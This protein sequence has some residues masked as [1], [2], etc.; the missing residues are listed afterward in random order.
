MA[1][2]NLVQNCTITDNSDVNTSGGG[3]ADGISISAGTGNI[4]LHNLVVHN[5]DDGID[6]WKSQNA[7][8]AYNISTNNGIGGGNGM[9]YKCGGA[10]PS[11]TQ[12]CDHNISYNNRTAGF[13]TNSGA[14]ST[15]NFNTSWNNDDAGFVLCTGAAACMGNTVVQNS[16]T[17]ANSGNTSGTG[18]T[19]NNSWQ[20]GGTP[21]FMS[22]DPTSPNF[23]RPT[24]GG[25][26]EDI[27]AYAGTTPSADVTP[28]SPPS[29]VTLH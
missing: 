2:F 6:T 12:L 3:N 26:F 1:S 25:G 23:L 17:L 22:V 9:G 20:R 8:V 15:F 13:D 11:N 5:S 21:A 18:T 4:I 27:G 7:H 10:A 16:L 29:G 24:V 28:P 14:N 19:T